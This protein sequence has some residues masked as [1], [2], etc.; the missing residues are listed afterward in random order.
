MLRCVLREKSPIG[1]WTPMGSPFTAG[2]ARDSPH[3]PYGR[4][5]RIT[6]IGCASFRVVGVA[7]RLARTSPADRRP[8][9]AGQSAPG[10]PAGAPGRPGPALGAGRDRI[11][12]LG[13][14][15]VAA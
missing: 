11:V 1:T 15:A 4:V 14:G 2:H 3:S 8:T 6:C 9:H 10:W 5:H 13:A 12:G 7:S